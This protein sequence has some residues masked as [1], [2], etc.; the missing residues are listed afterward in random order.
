MFGC[1]QNSWGDCAAGPSTLW[2]EGIALTFG[3]WQNSWGWMRRRPIDFV[4][5]GIAGIA[6]GQRSGLGLYHVVNPHW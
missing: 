4:A 3:C 1:W 5:E 2:G 6:T